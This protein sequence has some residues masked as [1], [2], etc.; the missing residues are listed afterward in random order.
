MKTADLYP[1][2]NDGH[3]RPGERSREPGQYDSQLAEMLGLRRTPR[4]HRSTRAALGE[5]THGTTAY[6]HRE[7]WTR[8]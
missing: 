2:V 3:F 1:H 4:C 8:K 5:R 6:L 7:L